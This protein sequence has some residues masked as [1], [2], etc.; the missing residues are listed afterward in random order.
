[1]TTLTALGTGHGNVDPERFQTSWLLESS[2]ARVLID[3]G[4]PCAQRL[5]A[6]GKNPGD[7]DAVLLTHGHA[8]H[9]GGL[10]LLLQAVW[11]DGRH[12]LLPIGLPTHLEAPVSTWLDHTI[13]LLPPLD[14]YGY[15]FHFW[16]KPFEVGNIRITPQPTSHLK[17]AR[18]K[19]PDA[20][21]FAFDIQC[22]DLRIIFSGDIGSASDLSPLLE[23]PAD[24][25]VC[26]LSH[27]KPDDLITEFTGKAISK[28]LLS[29]VAEAYLSD[30]DE[31]LQMFRQKLGFDVCYAQQ[32]PLPGSTV[33]WP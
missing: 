19:N 10:A 6:V 25:V 22:D 27:I 7:L 11:G 29:H 14:G 28:L 9:I 1:M 3:A 17:S 30:A 13:S 31:I 12:S 8:D 21:A 5:R 20:E 24:L 18:K 23:L 26:E 2:S 32:A 16:P 33:S 15:S 4:E